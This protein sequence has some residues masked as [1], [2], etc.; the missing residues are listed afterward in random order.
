MSYVAYTVQAILELYSL[1]PET[2]EKKKKRVT[3]EVI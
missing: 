3:S 2:S 1:N